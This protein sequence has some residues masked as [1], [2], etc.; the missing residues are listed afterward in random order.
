MFKDDLG[1]D[2]SDLSNIQGF[3][4]YFNETVIRGREVMEAHMEL[5]N[6][7]HSRLN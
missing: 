5:P 1:N 3:R 6:I 2:E 4:R 7:E